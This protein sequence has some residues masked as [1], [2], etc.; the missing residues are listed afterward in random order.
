MPAIPAKRIFVYVATGLVVL[1]AGTLGLVAMRSGTAASPEGVVIQAGDPAGGATG[2][3]TGAAAG[4][5]GA[6]AGGG[7][8]WV[9]TSSSSTSTTRAPKMWVQV[10]GAVRR[11]GV[12]QVGADAR[13]FEAV[14]EAGG[15]TDDADQEAVALAAALSDGC[16]VYVP[17]I[18]ES[19]G[20]VLQTP[21]QSTAGIAGGSLGGGS[22]GGSSTSGAAGGI[23]SINSA[24]L[25]ELDALPGIGPALA[26]QIITYRE[27]NGPFISVDRLT[28]VPGIGPAKL[29]Q[30]RPL[31][32]L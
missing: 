10:A 9:T 32:G 25:E 26:Q 21:T 11:P 5:F 19:P 14:L 18:G 6:I 27:K 20:G 4:S 23:V 13:V 16:R 12:Y 28:D 15:F 29:E 3:A 8:A 24:T 30:L 22:G 31:V 1:V 2:G 17:R 7:D